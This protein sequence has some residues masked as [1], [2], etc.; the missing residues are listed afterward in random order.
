[1]NKNNI[2][3]KLYYYYNRHKINDKI[4]SKEQ[5]KGITGESCS[6]EKWCGTI[7]TGEK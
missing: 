2:N 3:I 6:E 1:M 4:E 5:G 7:N